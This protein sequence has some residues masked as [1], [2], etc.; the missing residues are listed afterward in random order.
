MH[1]LLAATLPAHADDAK[2]AVDAA[3]ALL[4]T[5]AIAKDAPFSTM[6]QSVAQAHVDGWFAVGRAVASALT[7]HTD[8]LLACKSGESDDACVQRFFTRFLRLAFRHRP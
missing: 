4:P 1:D 7:T 8:E 2:S 5:D 3:L 6:D